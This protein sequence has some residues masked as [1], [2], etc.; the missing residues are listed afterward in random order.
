VDL[1]LVNSGGQQLAVWGET[2]KTVKNEVQSKSRLHRPAL[3]VPIDRMGRALIAN[4]LIAPL[5]SNEVRD[6]RKEKYNRS[7]PPEWSEY[8][9]DVQ[10]A[11][12]FF[13]GYDRVC[14]NQWLADRK[15]QSSARYETL[16]KLLADDR[17]WIN[18]QSSHCMHYLAVELSGLSNTASL[19][20][21]CGGRTPNYN[22]NAVFRSLLV[23][24]TTDGSDDGLERD[25]RVHSTSVFPFLAA[26]ADDSSQ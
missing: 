9:G 2:Y 15:S 3:G 18:S 8:S 21:D 16:A 7:T 5:D 1:D 13:D 25:D 11:L 24:G 23:R 10:R 26:P 22:A 4:M 6:A 14:G 19:K 12:G 17:I 20:N